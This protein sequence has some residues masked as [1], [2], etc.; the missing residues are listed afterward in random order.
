MAASVGRLEREPTVPAVDLLI[1]P[2]QRLRS[3]LTNIPTLPLRVL[4]RTIWPRV[5]LAAMAIKAASA[6]AATVERGMEGQASAESGTSAW[7][8]AAALAATRVTATA[9]LSSMP[10]PPRLSEL[11]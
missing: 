5:V 8:E 1:S 3:R 2:A 10:V 9:A 7:G 4:S 11:P 6:S